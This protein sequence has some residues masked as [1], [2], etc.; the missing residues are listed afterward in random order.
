MTSKSSPF[1]ARLSPNRKPTSRRMGWKFPWVSSSRGDFNFDYHV[2]FAK[3]QV[4]KGRIDYNFGTITDDARYIGEEL[5]GIGVFHKDN[6]GHVYLT[7]SA[8]ARGLRHPAWRASLRRSHT[9]GSSGVRRPG[10]V[11]PS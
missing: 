4:D 2:S 8:Y 1:R 7:Y 6:A 3:D 5:P 9:Q 10:R 11:A